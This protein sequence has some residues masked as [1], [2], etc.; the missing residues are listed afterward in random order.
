[1]EEA[2]IAWS[3]AKRSSVTSQLSGLELY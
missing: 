2:A 3:A 1:V